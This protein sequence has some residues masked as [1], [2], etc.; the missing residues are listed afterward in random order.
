MMQYANK[1]IRALRSWAFS[2]GTRV[3]L[4]SIFAAVTLIASLVAI[5]PPL[6][7]DLAGLFDRD[8]RELKVIGAYLQPRTDHF[9]NPIFKDF[10]EVVEVRLRL[11]NLS[12][13]DI[14]I[15][16]MEAVLEGDSPLKFATASTGALGEWP[17]QN[18]PVLLGRGKEV[19]LTFRSGLKLAGITPFFEKSEFKGQFFSETGDFYMMHNLTWI[20][21]LNEQ[22]E[23]LYGKDASLEVRFFTGYKK[24]IKTHHISFSDGQDLFDKSGRLQHDKFMGAIRQIQNKDACKNETQYC[25]KN[26]S[27]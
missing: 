7:K 3:F 2:S 21:R 24:L 9:F 4:S 20:P 25:I 23:N 18:S 27:D 10:N 8:I 6:G 26:V 17:E 11:K 22:L 13:N 12:N 19:E 15:T 5:Y 1:K 16:S 14:L